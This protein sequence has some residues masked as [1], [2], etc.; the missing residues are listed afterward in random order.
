MG[1]PWRAAVLLVLG[2]G[3]PEVSAGEVRVEVRR[4]ADRSYCVEGAFIVEASTA[5]VWAVLT[6]YDHI[7]GYVSAMKR[8]RLVESRV[9]GA[10][11]V[12]QEATGGAFIFSRTVRV[13]LEIRREPGR[14]SFVDVGREDFWEY[15]GSWEVAPAGSG[16]SEVVYRLSALPDFTVPPFLMRSG[17]RKGARELME[18]V[19]A[20]IV[21]RESR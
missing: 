13:V 5:A 12:E 4:D 9:D 10:V 19:R 1:I 3:A 15:S 8:S 21:R 16:K 17:L 7:G 2:L 18:Q 6:D 11:V 14:L 20:E